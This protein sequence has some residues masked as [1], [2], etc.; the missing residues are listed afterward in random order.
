MFWF[1]HS[2]VTRHLIG[3]GVLETSRFLVQFKTDQ[4]FLNAKV[5]LFHTKLSKH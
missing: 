2:L 3:D 5:D 1:V 4:R